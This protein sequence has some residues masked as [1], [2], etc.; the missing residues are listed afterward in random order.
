MCSTR[1]RQLPL[2][3]AAVCLLLSLP[4]ALSVAQA[5]R[6]GAN[7]FVFYENFPADNP[8]QWN[9]QT[10]KDGSRTYLSAGTYNIVRAKPGTMRGWPLAI[11]VP[12]ALQF[13]VKLRIVS[14][15]DPYA[16][17]SFWDDLANNFV[18]F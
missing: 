2:F 3:V 8:R 7:T 9:V 12:T 18:L 16:G 6:A 4:G 17:I 5:T 14:G 15:T 11:A 10:L 13:N 1:L